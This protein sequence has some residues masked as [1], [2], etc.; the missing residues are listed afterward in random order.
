MALQSSVIREFIKRPLVTNE[1]TNRFWRHWFDRSAHF[2][3]QG[4]VQFCSFLGMEGEA[5]LLWSLLSV[6][7]TLLLPSFC[8]PIVSFDSGVGSELKWKRM[9]GAEDDGKRS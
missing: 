4:K 6:K 3:A 1:E 7:A 5:L 9:G 2:L 8:R